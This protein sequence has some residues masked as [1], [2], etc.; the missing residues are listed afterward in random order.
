MKGSEIL[1]VVLEIIE[2]GGYMESSLF[3]N[4]LWFAKLF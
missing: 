4:V 1:L 3:L 2:I